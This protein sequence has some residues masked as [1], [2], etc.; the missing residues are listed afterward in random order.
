MPRGTTVQ[1]CVSRRRS[2]PMAPT[3][4][5]LRN[6]RG[7]RKGAAPNLEVRSIC[8]LASHRARGDVM[9]CRLPH[10]WGDANN[11]R[12]DGAGGNQV[13]SACGKGSRCPA[14]GPR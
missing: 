7:H 4:V 2:L 14:E 6:W 11:S 10:A 12:T 3:A 9:H 5:D 13:S 8:V 1:R